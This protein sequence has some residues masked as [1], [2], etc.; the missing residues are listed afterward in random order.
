M[1]LTISKGQTQEKRQRMENQPE[2]EVKPA[3][4][5][6]GAQHAREVRSFFSFFLPMFAYSE[7]GDFL[8]WVATAT[9]LYLAHALTSDAS[10]PHSLSPLLDVFVCVY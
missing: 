5:I 9:S 3:F 4:V 7:L 8:Q 2:P 10:E 6:I 1:G